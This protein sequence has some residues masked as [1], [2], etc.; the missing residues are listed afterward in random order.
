MIRVKCLYE[1]RHLIT[2]VHFIVESDQ[3][4]INLDQEV[5]KKD[6]GYNHGQDPL[7]AWRP[8]PSAFERGWLR[9]A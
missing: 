6:E 4:V 9:W 2:N 5:D 3:A 1:N 7:S 8:K